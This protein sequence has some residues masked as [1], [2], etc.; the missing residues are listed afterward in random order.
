M[1]TG[2]DLI[3]AFASEKNRDLEFYKKMTKAD[4]HFSHY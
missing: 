4:I 3:F 2:L 1:W